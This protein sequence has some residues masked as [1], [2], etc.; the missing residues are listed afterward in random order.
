[1][2][3]RRFRVVALIASYNEERF[4]APCIEHLVDQGVEVYLIDNESTDRTVAAAEAYLGNGLIGIETFKTGEDFSLTAQL[5]RKEELAATI[6]ADWFMHG[7]PDEFRLPPPSS[8]SLVEAFA[9]VDRAGYNAV[10]FLEF[11]FLPTV[12]APDHDH[13]G[14]QA[15]MRHYYPFQPCFPHLLKAWKR[16]PDRVQLVPSAGHRVRFPGLRMFPARLRCA[17]TC[18]SARTTRV[19]STPGFPPRKSKRRGGGDGGS[20]W[21]SVVC[22]QALLCRGRPNCESMWETA[23]LIRRSR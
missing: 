12:E 7:D 10:N 2:T 16:Q 11:T 18:S 4:I 1:M 8:G 13:V 22:R 15:T 21:P 9:E 3:Q 6:D 5:E 19:K 17:T 20:R 23:S 14:F